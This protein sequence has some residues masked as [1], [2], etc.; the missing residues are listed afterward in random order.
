MDRVTR[1]SVGSALLAVP[2]AAL[3][4]GLHAQA[5][6]HTTEGPGA[7]L[8]RRFWSAFN[9]QAWSELD[10]L[11]ATDYAHHTPSG[12]LDLAHFKE[13]GQWVHRGLANYR[14]AI[15]DLLESATTVAIRWTATGL[16][17]GSFFGEPASGR[18]ITTPGMHFHRIARG[19]IAEDWEVIDFDAFRRQLQPPSQPD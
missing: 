16:H 8:V 10:A 9:R 14:L 1:R 18:L 5:A 4:A 12:S 7:A 6:A 19:R 13:G 15:E 2:V 17:A 11:V 3:G